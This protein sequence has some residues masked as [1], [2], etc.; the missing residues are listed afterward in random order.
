MTDLLPPKKSFTAVTQIIASIAREG[1]Q[2]W[3]SIISEKGFRAIWPSDIH[4]GARC[5]KTDFPPDFIK[6]H[7]ADCIYLPG[8]WAYETALTVNHDFNL[9]RRRF[10][11]PYWSLSAVCRYTGGFLVPSVT[12]SGICRD[13][14]SRR[15]A[16]MCSCFACCVVHGTF[17]ARA[18]GRFGPPPGRL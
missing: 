4:L 16:L 9:V 2:R 5:C 11:Y 7:K 8:D 17:M 18:V 6:H 15:A 14:P 10:G 12:G 3:S 13:W 1:E